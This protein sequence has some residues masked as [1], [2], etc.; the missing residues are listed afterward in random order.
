MSKCKETSKRKIAGAGGE[1]KNS[2]SRRGG[3]K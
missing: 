1:E 2:W 3:E